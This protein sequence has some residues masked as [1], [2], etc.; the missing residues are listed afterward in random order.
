[1]I[2][3]LRFQCPLLFD[4][5]FVDLELKFPWLLDADESDAAQIAAIRF[6]C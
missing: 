3:R 2:S 5:H 4:L 1:M 6:K